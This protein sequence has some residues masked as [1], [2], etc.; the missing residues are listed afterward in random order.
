MFYI[1]SKFEKILWVCLINLVLLLSS[2]LFKQIEKKNTNN[3]VSFD[4][5]NKWIIAS[6]AQ[7]NSALND[8]SHVTQH[9]KLKELLNLF[10]SKIQWDLNLNNFCYELRD[11]MWLMSCNEELNC[12]RD[13]K[14]RLL[15]QSKHAKLLVFFFSTH[16]N[17]WGPDGNTR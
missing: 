14:I 16:L 17:K 3:F 10:F 4:Y 15:I 9:F 6:C 13:E 12:A 8:R 1:F 11:V 2:H 5:I 7:F